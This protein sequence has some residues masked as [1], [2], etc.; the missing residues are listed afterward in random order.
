M[1]HACRGIPHRL[2]ILLSCLL[3]PA[4]AFAQAEP[5]DP[6][7]VN[8]ATDP[9]LRGFQWRAIGPIGQGGRIDDIE[10]VEGNTSTY[11]IGF[12]TGGLWK[13]TNNGTTFESIFDSYGTHSIG[14]LAIAPSNPDIVYV[15]TGEPNNRQ[16]SSFGDGM[17][18]T[19]D[20]GR[21]FTHIGLRE[22]QSIG[23]VIVHPT[24]P[25]IVWVAAVG[26]LYGPNA[27]RGVFKTT[28]GG[29]TW[30]AVLQVDASTGATDIVIDPVNPNYLLAAM[31]KRQR[32]AWGFASGGG[33]TGIWR[34][35]DGGENWT[36]L[37]GN[38]LPAGSLGRIALSFGR[39]NPNV[40]YAQM[41]VAPDREPVDPAAAGGGGRGGGGG[42]GRGQAQPP[43]P[44][45]HGVWR[46]ADK[47]RT[48]E[49]RSNQN[50]RPMYFSQIRVD[51]NDENTVYVGGV[52]GYKST[53]GA[54]TWQTLNN[55]GHVDH[56]AI[57]IN[58]ANSQ[59]VM[60][61]NDG[62][63]DVSH[64][65]GQNWE[66]LRLWP[67][68]QPYHASVDMRRPYYVCT[69]LQDNGTWCGPSSVRTGPILKEDWYGVGGGDGFYTAVDPRDWTVV[70]SESQNGNTNRYNLRTGENQSIRPRAPGGGGRG[71]NVPSNIV[72]TPPEGTQLRHNW[73]TPF[74][75][76]PHNPD[77]VHVGSNRLHTSYNRG[78]TWTMSEDLT[79]S[80]DREAFSIMGMRGDVPGCGRGRVGTCILSKNDGVNV[81]GTIVSI[82]ESPIVQGL[83]WV[84]TDD[85][86]V[87]VSRDGGQT[88]TE[89]GRNVPG[90]TKEYYVSRVEASHAD[91]ATAYISVDGHRHNDLRP[92][93][94]VTKD[95][96]QTWTS[97]AS[98]L[99]AMGNVNTVRQ[100][101]RNPNLL[102][103]GTEFGF[104]VSVD[105]GA[106]W[107]R[108][109]T[110]LP[111]VRVDDV[112]VHPRDNDLVLATHGRSIQVMDDITALQQLTPEIMTEPWHLMQPRV[113]VLW[114]NDR[115]M[116]RAVTGQKVFEGASAPTGT[117][118]SYYLG[119][120][121]PG[122]VQL[123]VTDMSTG[124]LFRS[125]DT[126]RQQ[127]LNRIQWDLCSDRRPVD[128]A[129]GGGRGGFGGFGGGCGGGGGGRGGQGDPPTIATRAT[130][131][132][133]RVTLTIG[134]RSQSVNLNVLDDIW[135]HER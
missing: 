90:G 67:V 39:S 4:S 28:D 78:D 48:W 55:H 18:R 108:F 41:E 44:N 83:L 95:Y 66:S 3:V 5:Q 88:W 125:I 20:G 68:G 62:G 132:V 113:A 128:P 86:N 45:Y 22:T 117:F 21:T 52:Q 57:W 127:G 94:Y 9:L 7:P 126:T 91:P 103:A 114:K 107:K 84:G 74:M 54:R 79:K 71:G 56:H 53:D 87:Q 122:D 75:L 1:R 116:A 64:D 50:V 69:G 133:Y 112:L 96:G 118:I 110:N 13:T 134:G 85:G 98:D 100:D 40:V 82:T 14:D 27:E 26:Q 25:D 36:R 120:V 89:V 65:G 6:P 59:H 42:G 101:P 102:Y 93:V 51:P 37:A 30:R 124:E 104:F 15:G 12:A 31:Y 97:I 63:L 80:N 129:G 81:W 8:R 76:S 38:G 92:Y 99:P 60:Y 115:R 47:G 123:T 19:T 77:V 16:S 130:P 29:R 49:F 2:L 23:R 106:S 72:P 70:Y 33:G 46:S 11:Y 10:V 43:D 61:G 34:S 58:P 24:D 131:G 32:T 109:M 105:E 35:E 119:S 17:Y 135:M 73:N 121:P 111:V